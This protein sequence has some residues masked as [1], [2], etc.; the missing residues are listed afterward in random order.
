MPLGKYFL[1]LK[2]QSRAVPLQVRAAQEVRPKVKIF[3]TSPIS[4]VDTRH[5][6]WE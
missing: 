1:R 6:N 4:I 3:D 2:Q 5:L